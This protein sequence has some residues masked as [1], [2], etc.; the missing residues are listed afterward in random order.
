[1]PKMA[2][3]QAS[4]HRSMKRPL[5]RRDFLSTSL[6][7]GAAAFTTGLL[8]KYSANADRQYNVLFIIIDD[9]RPML[10]CYGH[11]EMHTPNIDRIAEQGTLFNRAYCQYP[12]CSP[13]RTSMITG[14]R[15]ETTNVLNNSADFRR[16][17]PDVVTLPQHF[18]AH[19]YHTQSVGRVFH[20]PTLQDDENSWS[21]PSWRPVWRPFDIQTTPSW[22][23]LDVEDDELRDGETA[24]R[25]VQVLEK[26]KEQQFFL[27]V[28]FYK[29]HLPWKAPRKYFDLYNT[30]AFNLPASSMPPK[31][32][33]ARALTNWSAIRAYKDLPSGTEPL[34]D[35]KTLELIWAYAAVTSYMDAQIGRVLTQLD[36]LGLTENTVIVFCGDH[37]HHLGEHGIWGKQT[38]FEVSLRSPLIVSVPG[39]THPKARTNALAELVDIYPTLCGACQIPIPPQ[40]EGTS[41]MPVIEQPTR[42]WKTATFSRFGGTV[43][44]GV[45][46]RTERYR[47]TERGEN[48][49]YGRE[50]YDYDADRNETINIANLPENA[51]LVTHLSERLHAGWQ[52][53]LPE[54]Q[55]QVL[56]PQTLPWDVN[57]DGL[58]NTQDLIMVSNNFDV[59]SPEPP[60]VDVNK[61]GRV[62]LIDLLLVAA[63]FGEP[64]DS[65]APSIRGPLVAQHTPLIDEW[66]AEARLADDG[67]DVFRQGIA[68]LERLIHTTLPTET[69]LLPNYPNP[70]N[71]ETWIPYDLAKD[72][73]VHIDIYNLK[74][75]SI[76]R[77]SVGFQRAGTYRT[78]SR[79]AYW[80][81]RNAVGEAVASGIYFYTFQ[82][83]QFRATRQMVILK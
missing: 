59:V 16:K 65:V 70:F 51:E 4:E 49:R 77:L 64:D 34:S 17:L 50:L 35:A 58:V 60:K 11:P 9:L 71:P 47:Y 7:A 52:T 83:G 74:G 36:T 10:G 53:A 39:Q 21:V 72:V 80:D 66:L 6:K 2:V 38:L 30:Q 55:A 44:G 57:D 33:P 61:D 56:V 23:A 76:R 5:T 15:P 68:A 8:P 43:A 1:M 41:L 27:T 69:T 14:L 45:S 82:A 48:A 75:E 63:H 46:I 22:Q 81:G 79:A 20:L 73:D 19:G 25:A 12:L 54:M 40:L 18:K 24:K 26:I 37:G 13:S 29:P 42:P 3:A 67:S 28:G 62:D 78:S 31:D 32:A